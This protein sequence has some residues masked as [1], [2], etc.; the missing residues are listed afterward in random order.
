MSCETCKVRESMAKV[1]DVHWTGASDCPIDCPCPKCERDSCVGR[2]RCE[3]INWH[4]PVK[5]SSL[6]VAN[7][8]GYGLY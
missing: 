4:E 2:S 1:F 8:H 3:E 5:D 6:D 7:R